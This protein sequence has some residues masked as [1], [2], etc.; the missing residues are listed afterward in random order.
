M[1]ALFSVTQSCPTPCDP[2]DYRPPGSSVHG[3]LL[4][5]ILEWVDIS[6]SKGYSQLKTRVSCIAGWFFTTEPPRKPDAST[7]RL[8]KHMLMLGEEILKAFSHGQSCKGASA[9]ALSESPGRQVSLSLSAILFGIFEKKGRN[10]LSITEKP[11]NYVFM[12]TDKNTVSTV[13]TSFHWSV[14]SCHPT[15]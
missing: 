15:P 3:M 11:K 5:R 7:T 12:N 13:L 8:E 14:I 10:Y 4:A 6:F 2:V 1:S 9:R